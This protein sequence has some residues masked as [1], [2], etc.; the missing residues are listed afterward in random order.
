MPW[1]VIAN[2]GSIMAL[3]DGVSKRAGLLRALAAL[4]IDPARTIA[5]GD[6]E[7]NLDMLGL[8]GLGVAV[9]NALP[10]VKAI[11]H[12]VTAHDRGEG[13]EELVSRL[14]AG[15]FEDPLPSLASV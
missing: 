3:P 5:L 2:K 4:D 11:A 6:A 15:E 1:Q 14:L 7:N 12:V 8:C 9:N 10:V 13:V